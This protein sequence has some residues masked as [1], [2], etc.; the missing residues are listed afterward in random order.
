MEKMDWEYYI[1]LGDEDGQDELFGL[2][3][4]HPIQPEHSVAENIQT[5]AQGS[6]IENSFT[7]PPSD[8]LD[9]GT[10]PHSTPQVDPQTA[11]W[12]D[13]G[14]RQLQ[15]IIR[16]TPFGFS[17]NSPPISPPQSYVHPP[18][19]IRG[20]DKTAATF[21][22]EPTTN[23]ASKTASEFKPRPDL[24][25]A[26]HQVLD[27]EPQQARNSGQYGTSTNGISTNHFQGY[28]LTNQPNGRSSS[29]IALSPSSYHG[30]VL[31]ASSS[32]PSPST[33]GAKSIDPETFALTS[34]L[35]NA[36]SY[37]TVARPEFISLL[38]RCRPRMQIFKYPNVL[39][40]KLLQ[41]IQSDA[42]SQFGRISDLAATLPERGL[43]Q[44]FD[45][46]ELAAQ[47]TSTSASG[48]SQVSPQRKNSSK[49]Y[50]RPA[51]TGFDS[52]RPRR[53]SSGCSSPPPDP[54]TFHPQ[55]DSAS[56]YDLPDNCERCG[57]FF[58]GPDRMKIH[59]RGC[60]RKRGEIFGL[61][62]PL[63]WPAPTAE[64]GAITNAYQYP[65]AGASDNSR[66]Q[67][68]TLRDTPDLGSATQSMLPSMIWSEASDGD[69]EISP[70]T[71]SHNFQLAHTEEMKLQKQDMR[72]RW[73]QAMTPTQSD[74]L[75]TREGLP[76]FYPRDTPSTG[77]Y[78]VQPPIVVPGH[79]R[80]AS[81]ASYGSLA[82]PHTYP[83]SGTTQASP[84]GWWKPYMNDLSPF[85]VDEER[86][87]LAR[88]FHALRGEGDLPWGKK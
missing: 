60:A 76:A 40:K 22:H 82:T 3:D 48:T 38:Q 55:F 45:P 9:L 43:K 65:F 58:N 21:T 74:V 20:N 64:A 78:A 47:T 51:K 4:L 63:P 52:T 10:A 71:E 49:Q 68:N 57:R 26:S 79:Q 81:T 18:E 46:H 19:E 35:N 6:E 27:I 33:I 15:N 29:N 84:Y 28:N 80:E 53:V 72:V 12:Q 42:R 69:D 67:R 70:S 77:T 7:G 32:Y 62:D 8:S 73:P 16:N 30:H 66:S 75:P 34:Q 5:A 39:T 13:I 41:R 31:P 85:T 1:P 87:S 44:F 86:L 25:P 2:Q 17:M 36:N 56:D 61:S 11:I 54:E 59:L 37:P 24:Q 23:L 14:A 83:A 50:A 88:A